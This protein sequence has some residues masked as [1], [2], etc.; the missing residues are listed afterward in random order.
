LRNEI[1]FKGFVVTD[2]LAANTAQSTESLGA[3]I[4]VMGGCSFGKYR[5]QS[6]GAKSRNG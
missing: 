4:D 5:H 2:W 3:G 1:K 6:T